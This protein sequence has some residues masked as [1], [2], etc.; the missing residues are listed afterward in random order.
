[1]C[2]GAESRSTRSSMRSYGANR[3][4]ALRSPFLRSAWN[5]CLEPSLST[6][7]I[8]RRL[9][10]TCG[11]VEKSS[12]ACEKRLGGGI[13]LFTP[14]WRLP[15]SRSR[16]LAH[17]AALSGRRGT[18]RIVTGLKR[19]EPVVVRVPAGK[20]RVTIRLDDDVLGWFREQVDRAG[21]GNYQSLINQA[22]H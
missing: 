3:R 10:I 11:L 1:M 22:L 14:S 7:P 5:R 6:S 21:G 9:T 15:A 16:A 20:T 2:S 4:K 13:R 18:T 19:Q 12:H 17:E 8:G